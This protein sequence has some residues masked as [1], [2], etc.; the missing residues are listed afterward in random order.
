LK[1]PGSSEAGGQSAPVIAC[2]AQLGTSV[3]VPTVESS[4]AWA[5]FE[6]LTI[7]NVDGTPV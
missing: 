6:L 2:V 1:T 7:V 3:I 5:P 4:G